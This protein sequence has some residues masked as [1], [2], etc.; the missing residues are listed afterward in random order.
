MMIDGSKSAVIQTGCPEIAM[1][2]SDEDS[3]N[4]KTAE[5]VLAT[6]WVALLITFA[7]LVLDA[8][9]EGARQDQCRTRGL[10]SCAASSPEP[11]VPGSGGEGSNNW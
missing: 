3:P 8:I 6:L 7:A 2:T 5:N 4:R 1:R 11:Q 10:A 9:L